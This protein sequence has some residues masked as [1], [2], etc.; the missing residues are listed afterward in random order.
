MCT[1]LLTV[2]YWTGACGFK[3]QGRICH[4]A[5]GLGARDRKAMRARMHE[6]GAAAQLRLCEP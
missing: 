3:A 2:Q 4:G 6:G 1:S 5:G